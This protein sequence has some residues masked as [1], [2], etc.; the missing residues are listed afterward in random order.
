MIPQ[1]TT[2]LNNIQKLDMEPNDVTG[3]TGE[4]LQAVY[5]KAPNDIK[6]YINT[7]L[8]PSLLGTN[9]PLT[10]I[11][12]LTGTDIQTVLQALKTLT[13]SNKTNSD[14][15]LNNHKNNTSNPHVVTANQLGVYTKGELDPFLR[16][17]DTLIKVEVFTIVNSNLGDGTFSY[18]DKNAA[19]KIGSLDVEGHQ[20][21]TLQDGFYDLG[22][23]RIEAVINDTLQRSVASGGLEELSP[24]VVSLTS[25]EG[26]GAEITLKYY[27]RLGVV[28]TGL[29]IMSNTPGP[30]FSIHD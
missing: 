20:L 16:G 30:Y 14:L 8:I 6:T 2:D 19:I 4:L 15:L 28:G 24:T 23:N 22:S 7:V 1:L 3:L 9:L 29:I 18:S 17:G 12:G 10:P 5:D 13:D 21:F 26:V 27:E 25:P 11:D